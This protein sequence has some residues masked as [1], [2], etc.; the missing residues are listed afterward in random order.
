MGKHVTPGTPHG[1]QRKMFT[2]PPMSRIVITGIGWVTPLGHDIETV[3]A[4]LLAG[5]SGASQTD[6][7]DAATFPT[8]FSAQVRGYDYRKFV[9]RP[10]C[11]DGIGLNTA[12]ALGA[13]SQAW[14]M[15]GLDTFA[16]LKSERCG[17]YLGSGEGSLDSANYFATNIAGWDEATQK[18]DGVKWAATG[19]RRFSA[20]KEM[21]Q[22]PNQ[23]LSHI[24]MEFGIE[25]PAYNCL[26]ACA[27]STQALGEAFEILNRGDADVMIAGGA[28]TMIHPLGVTGFNRL[29][30]LSNRNE[31]PP[32]PRAPSPPT[33]TAS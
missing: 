24:A 23:P 21:E 10:E 18:V 19:Y 7:F 27:A 2:I 28:H 22:E 25:G 29:T 16:G 26:T 30:A 4:N 15:A 13:A 3:W 8:T 14:K 11:H 33:A 32:P 12:F 1:M 9:S 31:S 17:I 20:V 5:K 6:R